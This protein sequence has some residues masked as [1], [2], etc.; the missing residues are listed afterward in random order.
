MKRHLPIT[1]LILSLIP[2]TWNACSQ[3][4][5]GFGNDSS[6]TLTIGSTVL[7]P[8]MLQQ[9]ARS[10]MI[11][12]CASCHTATG[13]PGN[14]Y[15]LT[16]SVHLISSGLVVP[17]NPEQSQIYQSI[18]SGAM[19]P[20]GSLSVNDKVIVREWIVA[21]ADP[22]NGSGG[23]NG[24]A[25]VPSPQGT[26]TSTPPPNVSFADLQATI[27][28]LKCTGCHGA[29]APAAQINLTTYAGVRTQV[30]LGTPSSSK[31][32]LSVTTGGMPK[33]AAALASGDINKILY[34]IQ[35][36]APNN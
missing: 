9:L 34:W 7:P 28:Q 24:P 26:P 3:G 31:L 15:N 23:S 6:A 17:G 13:G 20:G 27:F 2:I 32:Y 8:A 36:G 29:T 18:V 11:D 12:N 4:P 25:P 10:I 19:P 33:N 35:N 14:V 22:S 5:L 21:M 16:D 30:N 1:L